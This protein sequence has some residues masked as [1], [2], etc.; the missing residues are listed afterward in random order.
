MTVAEF[1]KKRGVPYHRAVRWIRNGWITGVEITTFGKARFYKVPES[2]L[3]FT[4]PKKGP[5][6]GSKKAKK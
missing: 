1:A 2:A 5:K 6:P 4:P 3:K